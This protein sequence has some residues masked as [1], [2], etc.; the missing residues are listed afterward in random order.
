MNTLDI[1]LENTVM[2]HFAFNLML[3]ACSSLGRLFDLRV[4]KSYGRIHRL[5][6]L[7]GHL[8]Q[9]SF[10]HYSLV[11]IT[12]Y[13]QGLYRV[14]KDQMLSLPHALCLVMLKRTV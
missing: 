10:L 9:I 3:L 11:M 12:V 1:C 8:L 2:Q 6:M 7:K 5:E 13:F 4:T 14:V